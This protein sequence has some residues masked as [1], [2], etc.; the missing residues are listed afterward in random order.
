MDN[1]LNFLSGLQKLEQ[2]AKKCIELRG[3]YVEQIP[4]LV[5]VACFLPGRAK[6][7]SAPPNIP[8]HNQKLSGA[9]LASSQ[10]CAG[11]KLL[12][13]VIQESLKV[14]DPECLRYQPFMITHFHTIIAN[15]HD[16]F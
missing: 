1:L 6:G 10:M 2:Q 9:D 8:F 3:E 5:V 13:I 15:F 16:Q 7:L 12:W 4:S 14:C 11:A